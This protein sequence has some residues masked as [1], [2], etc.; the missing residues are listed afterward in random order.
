[1]GKFP[2]HW[3]FQPA[4]RIFESRKII[5]KENKEKNI[6]SLTL[7]GVIR[8]NA[9]KPIG[10]SPSDY[11]TYQIFNANELVFKLI[12]LENISTSRVGIVNE[13]GIMSSAYIRFCLK[14]NQNLRYFYFFYMD[15][16]Y[17]HIF[18]G[19]GAGVRQT[20]SANDLLNMN[21]LVPPREEQDQIV[22]YLDW[23]IK[24]LND[25]ILV[26]KRKIEELSKLR[27]SVIDR[28]I[29]YGFQNAEKKESH[30]TWLGKIPCLWEILPLKRIC[31]VNASISKQLQRL[32][33]SDYVTF[34]P[35][36]NITTNGE[37]DISEKRKLA[38]VRTGFSSFAKGDVVIA[39]I[40][41]CFENG[42]GACLDVLDTNIGFGT[43]ELINLRPTDKIISKY[44]YYITMTR[45]FRKLGEIVMTGS[46]G[47]KR[48]PV[49]FVKNFVL[50]IPE[51]AEQKIIVRI[52]EDKLS[53]INDLISK[54][55]KFI[56]YLDDFKR[57]L[58]SDVVTGQINVRHIKV[59][60]DFQ[61][62]S[63]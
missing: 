56:Q 43:T 14:N 9:D 38:E 11:S 31:K 46:A 55:L 15:W 28:G 30:I 26:S 12:D 61:S 20:L 37:I 34:L 24:N 10:L 52:I 18:N 36:E 2:L 50:G 23:Q 58:I 39:K 13:R 42:K 7:R 35:M 41:P 5:N 60:D 27:C 19:L 16:Y 22:R 1:M 48:V 51:I 21:I 44:L 6:L 45:P 32:K 17:R 25:L 59:P 3:K 54:E 47:Q 63:K 29:L 53:A 57:C 49:S 33:N 8:N 40:T 62:E 4:K